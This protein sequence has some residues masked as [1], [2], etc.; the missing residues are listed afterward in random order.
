M[1]Q[2]NLGTT[3]R[4]A[5]ATLALA[6]AGCST[7]KTTPEASSDENIQGMWKSPDS[8]A[9]YTIVEVDGE[10]TVA[11]KSSFSGKEMDIT[12]VSWD[13]EIL[14]FTSHMPHTEHTIHHENK[15]VDADTM[16][17]SATGDSTHQ[18]TWKKE[19]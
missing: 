10:M 17:S 19:P 9:V 15:L 1:K 12:N 8:V 3:A 7:S 13:G 16:L 18:T 5:L 2:I 4:L 14:K 11:G 6:A